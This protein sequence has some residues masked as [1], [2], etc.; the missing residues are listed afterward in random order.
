MAGPRWVWRAPATKWGDAMHE[1]PDHM[2]PLL[3]GEL[4]SPDVS[5]LLG[6]AVEH[7][8]G[9]GGLPPE[10]S[11]AAA[12]IC[13]EA[14][15]KGHALESVLREVRAIL[16]REMTRRALTSSDRAALMALVADECVR[17]FYG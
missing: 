11:R 2:P 10:L 16:Q 13:R 1:E 3:G 6:S 15:T 17:A 5:V 4:L 14:H 8:T 9:A 12:A 7:Y